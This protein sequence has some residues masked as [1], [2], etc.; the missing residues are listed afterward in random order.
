MLSDVARALSARVARG[1]TRGSSSSGSSFRVTVTLDGGSGSGVVTSARS[2]GSSS[3]GSSWTSSGT[4]IESG[5]CSNTLGGRSDLESG[6]GSFCSGGAQAASSCSWAMMGSTDADIRGVIASD[7]PSVEPDDERNLPLLALLRLLTVLV[8]G[9]LLALGLMLD[10]GDELSCPATPA[11]F[12]GTGVARFHSGEPAETARWRGVPAVA[13]DKP[14]ALRRGVPVVLEPATLADTERCLGAVGVVGSNAAFAFDAFGVTAPESRLVLLD[15]DRAEFDGLSVDSDT[16]RLMFLDDAD[17]RSVPALL[18]AE[19]FAAAFGVACSRAILPVLESVGVSGDSVAEGA[20]GFPRPAGVGVADDKDPRGRTG[21]DTGVASS[22]PDAAVD[23]EAREAALA[24]DMVR[25]RGARALSLASP[26]K[27]GASGS[28]AI[29]AWDRVLAND[30]VRGRTLV[31]VPVAADEVV[32]V[33]RTRVLLAVDGRGRIVLVPGFGVAA[34]VFVA[35]GDRLDRGVVDVVLRFAMDTERVRNVFSSEGAVEPVLARDAGLGVSAG[36]VVLVLRTLIMEALFV[37]PDRGVGLGVAAG[38]S[39]DFVLLKLRRLARE[40]FREWVLSFVSRDGGP[41]VSG[42]RALLAALVTEA[43]RECVAAELEEDPVVILAGVGRVVTLAVDDAREGRAAAAA[44]AAVEEP[45]EDVRECDAGTV[46]AALAADDAVDALATDEVREWVIGRV[47]GVAVFPADA[48]LGVDTVLRRALGRDD[49]NDGR[50]VVAAF[51]GDL[52]AAFVGDLLPG[53]GRVV[54]LAEPVLDDAALLETEALVV[55]VLAAV[56]V[57][58][59]GVDRTELIDDWCRS[60]DGPAR[61]ESPFFSASLFSLETGRLPV[62]SGR[63]GPLITVGV[64]LLGLPREG[65][66]RLREPTET[67]R[68]FEAAVGLRGVGPEEVGV[69]L[70]DCDAAAALDAARD[71]VTDALD[72]ELESRSR[73]RPLRSDG[74]GVSTPR[75]VDTDA[76]F[77]CPGPWLV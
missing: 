24:I 13:G 52:L 34:G 27:G 5:R 22:A 39:V 35:E 4:T 31:P 73:R 68:V 55:G 17:G 44:L 45:T 75:R 7:G 76:R 58:A 69:C 60:V 21:L 51:V 9:E 62:R 48:A 41:P 30:D 2:P 6:D 20:T 18:G 36:F 74:S 57:L 37:M 25:V 49:D 23:V 59:E 50:L 1:V 42:V 40:P 72:A 28:S 15:S 33:V 56:G 10:R 54:D 19:G 70:L 43:L 14:E 61:G 38:D 46:A 64:G 47:V 26:G 67:T 32:E 63:G 77:A 8:D 66:T 11:T 71:D 65:E 12:G 3:C 16:L 29:V 53:V